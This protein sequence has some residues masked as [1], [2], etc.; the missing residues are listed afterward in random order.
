MK[1]FLL[2][3]VM[4]FGMANTTFAAIQEKQ[5]QL[6]KPSVENVGDCHYL[7]SVW[8]PDGKFVTAKNGRGS[9]DSGSD[10]LIAAL[11]VALG[12]EQKYP[13]MEIRVESFFNFNH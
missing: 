12:L 2:S 9:A 13:G 3:T 10:C 11:E 6:F 8:T 1:N 4:C 7:I 5:I